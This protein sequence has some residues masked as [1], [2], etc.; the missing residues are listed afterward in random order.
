MIQQRTQKRRAVSKRRTRRRTV[1]RGGR[2][3]S[4]FSVIY[5]TTHVKG[6]TLTQSE[7]QSPPIVRMPPGYS[8]VLYDP[9]AVN[10]AYIHWILGPDGDLLSYKGPTPP[11]GTGIHRYIFAFVKEVPTLPAKRNSQNTANLIKNPVAY[12]YFTVSS[13]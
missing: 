7:T 11:P 2:G 4:P 1:S 9:D 13:Y 8:V 5:G 6:Q 10:P 12:L 3:Q